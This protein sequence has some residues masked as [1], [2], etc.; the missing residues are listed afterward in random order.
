MINKII[1]A[2]TFAKEQIFG[3]ILVFSKV[4]NHWKVTFSIDI[5]PVNKYHK[6][7]SAGTKQIH[8][9]GIENLTFNHP[10]NLNKFLWNKNY[11]FPFIIESF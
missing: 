7:L 6:I 11:N 5:H 4:L 8:W 10:I 3:I 2:P 9:R 1:K